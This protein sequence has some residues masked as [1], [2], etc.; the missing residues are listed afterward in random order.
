V[1]DDAA[2][3]TRRA[4]LNRAVRRFLAAVLAVAA[5]GCGGATSTP[6]AEALVLRPADLG[7]GYRYGDDTG[8]GAPS[9]TEGDW[10]RL[11]PLF[12]EE[13][14]SACSMELQWAWKGEPPYARTVT[15]A[16]YVFRGAGAARRA[17][18]ARDELALF[19]AS[20]GVQERRTLDVGDEGEL[21]RGRGLNS[22]ASGAVWR[23]GSVV[24]VLVLEPRDEAATREL[25]G[26]Q[27]ERLEHPAT[28]PA[29]SE[30]DP[31]LQLDDP[32]LE[33]PVYWLGRTFDPPGD[34]PALDLEQAFVG[35]GGP[36]QGV[37][38]SYAIA[39]GVPASVTLDVWTPDAWERFRHTR[40]GRLIWDSPCARKRVVTLE[41]G[42]AEIFQGYGA[43]EP[44]GLP[45]PDRPPDRVIAHVYHETVVVAVDMPY[46][47]VCAAPQPR[48]SP[49]DTPAAMET[50]VRSLRLRQP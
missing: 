2:S 14:P 28:T 50:L 35:G 17:F 41:G 47:Y 46:C 13:R 25:A 7:T 3:A 27:Q 44:V 43:P 20:L 5:A 26:M 24:E 10:P 4:L 45:C 11:E 16:A 33:L 22:P 8:C 15:S 1:H 30:N 31:A 18:D 12:A 29:T 6:D 49:Y 32:S 40:L 34:L 38:L 42:R 48:P 9:A 37:Q 21:L 36:G 23:D 39:G 19:T